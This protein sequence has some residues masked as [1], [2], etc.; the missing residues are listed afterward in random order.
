MEKVIWS[1]NIT[2]DTL[3][4][5]SDEEKLTKLIELG[6]DPEML[7][8]ADL[9]DVISSDDSMYD[10]DIIEFEEYI[11]PEIEH[12]TN[13]GIVLLVDSLDNSGL[14]VFASE[15]TSISSDIEEYTLTEV[16]SGLMLTTKTNE[17]THYY[18]VFAVPEDEDKLREFVEICLP[19]RVTELQNIENYSYSEAVAEVAEEISDINLLL[20]Y[21]D[22]SNVPDVC[23]HVSLKSNIMNESVELTEVKAKDPETLAVEYAEIKSLSDEYGKEYFTSM[24]FSAFEDDPITI[25]AQYPNFAKVVKSFFKEMVPDEDIN[26]PDVIDYQ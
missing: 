12:Q 25:E 21:C 16:D 22:Y 2:K 4:N 5:S 6:Y 18:D 8:S 26:D 10:S 13:S 24:P 17:E 19:E 9:D 14:A 15:L 23:D 20:G 3:L 7:S 11:V 1:S